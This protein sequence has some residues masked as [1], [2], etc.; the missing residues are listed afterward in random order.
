[1][2]RE[3]P[4]KMAKK[5]KTKKNKK[6]PHYIRQSFM[7]NIFIF[8]GITCSLFHLGSVTTLLW[9]A[10]G[11]A[12]GSHCYTEYRAIP[13]IYTFLILYKYQSRHTYTQ[14]VTNFRYGLLWVCV[15]DTVIYNKRHIFWNRA[16]SSLKLL[17]LTKWQDKS[18][19]CYFWQDPFNHN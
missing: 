7:L 19:F 9:P 14:K 5:Q 17:E 8:N 15:Y 3:R 10:P 6:N 2:P 1:M 11:S 18:V 16:E 12:F 13:T 4:K